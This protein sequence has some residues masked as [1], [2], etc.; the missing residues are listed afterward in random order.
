[1]LRS[2][3]T[4]VTLRAGVLARSFS[5]GKGSVGFIGLGNMGLPMA[6]NL[7]NAG[8]A[9]KGYDLVSSQVAKLQEVGG[10]S[11]ASPADAADGADFVVTMLPSNSHVLEAYKG[12]NGVF[13]TARKGALLVDSSTVEPS[14]SREIYA[15]ASQAGNGC[16]DAPVSGGTNGAE[17]GTLTFMCGGS[18]GDFDAAKSLLEAMGKN[19]VLC[20]DAGNGQ[21]VKLCNN[22]ILGTTMAGISEAYALGL[23]LGA[24]PQKLAGII[25]TSSG[26]CWSSDTYNPV[27][28][29]MENVPSSRGYTGGFA[30][31]L[32]AKDMG[33]AHAAA[34]SLRLPLP[35][36]SVAFQMYAL[37]HNQGNGGKDFSAV[38]E[39][40]KKSQQ[41]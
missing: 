33:L 32:M 22:L 30:A 38:F 5:S 10:S 37:M 8:F 6:K 12:E 24:D 16:L 9:V 1:M 19:I 11:A 31:D 29:V 23:A 35:V 4:R 21:I 27:P 25:N 26:R 7:Q 14:V 36:G 39:L 2:S 18:E 15:I 20:G 28:G 34:H 40:V 3:L 41:K 13:K 17:A